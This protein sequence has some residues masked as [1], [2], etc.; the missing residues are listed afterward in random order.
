MAIVGCVVLFLEY[1][2]KTQSAEGKIQAGLPDVHK[3]KDFETLM[4]RMSKFGGQATS[5]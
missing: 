3:G 4:M 1:K 5:I 2:E